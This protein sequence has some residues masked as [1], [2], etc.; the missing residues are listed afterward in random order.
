MSS[1]SPDN[2]R[3]FSIN[4]LYLDEFAI[5]R[6]GLADEFMASVFPAIS[7]GETTRCIITS[8]PKGMNHFYDMWCKAIDEE[9]AEKE[10]ARNRYIKSTVIWNQVPSHTEEWG[11]AEREKVGD[12][13]FRQEYECEFIGSSITLIDYRCLEKLKPAVPLDFDGSIWTGD[14]KEIT[15]DISMRFFKWPEKNVEAKGYSYVASIDT[16]FGMRKDYH[17]L[18]ILLAKSNIKCE[19]VFA[20]SSNSIGVNEF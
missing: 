15:N 10:G 18:Q 6:P 19:Q 4:L 12:Q 14:L 11:A 2:I 3:G 5:L 16:G 13:R 1:S 8:T 17:V 7:S 20:M 9:V